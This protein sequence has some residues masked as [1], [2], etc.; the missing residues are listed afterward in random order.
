MNNKRITIEIIKELGNIN[1][2]AKV[3][4][5]IILLWAKYVEAQRAQT[6]L[7]DDLKDVKSFDTIKKS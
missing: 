4:S 3:P 2:D 1:K 5:T 6:A 7:L